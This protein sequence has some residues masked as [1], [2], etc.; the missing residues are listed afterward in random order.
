MISEAGEDSHLP[1]FCIRLV[2]FIFGGV[3]KTFYATGAE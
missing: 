2:P 3:K 1:F